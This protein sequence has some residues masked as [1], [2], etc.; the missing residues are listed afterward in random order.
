[1]QEAPDPPEYEPA[2]QFVQESDVEVPGS[3]LFPAR[4]AWQEEEEDDPATGLKVPAGHSSHSAD[5]VA[6]YVPVEHSVQPASLLT[7]PALSP[8]LPAAQSKHESG[9]EEPEEGLNVPVGQSSHNVG[10]VEPEEGLKEP[11]GHAVQDWAEPE[12]L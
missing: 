1:V 4:H 5:P 12:S 7:A 8:N 6:A 10:E 11:G 2:A 3:E 9:E